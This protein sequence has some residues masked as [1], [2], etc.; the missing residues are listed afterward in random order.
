M[1]S[2]TT[3]SM[4]ADASPSTVTRI[5]VSR[6]SPEAASVMEAAFSL[7]QSGV[8]VPCRP[9]SSA[10]EFMREALGLADD[11]IEAVVSTV[12]IDG[13][14]VDDIDAARVRDGS[15]MALS[16]AM[17]G[18]V[19]AVMRRNSPYASFRKAI[20]YDNLRAGAA[21]RPEVAGKTGVVVR[22]KL[23]NQVMRDLA[24]GILGKGV[25]V[26]GEEEAALAALSGHDAGNLS[27]RAG[28]MLI[29]IS[30]GGGRP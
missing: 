1:E 4:A 25:L 15:V 17:P 24:E 27:S 30:V 22:L 28:Q 19:G 14:P 7:L 18:L 10:R 13:E 16:A 2:D 6:G 12:F 29:V 21:G 23:F 8:G 9:G 3:V 5:E 11:Y 26:S 20:S